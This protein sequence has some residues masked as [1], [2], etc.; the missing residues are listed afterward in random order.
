MICQEVSDQD[1]VL[2]IFL[3]V[4]HVHFSNFSCTQLQGYHRSGGLKQCDPAPCPYWP[5]VI[6]PDR[7]NQ[8]VPRGFWIWSGTELRVAML[9][10]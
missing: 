4:Q 9:P 2:G 7:A 1:D 8:N 6:G 3:S 10:P 5:Q